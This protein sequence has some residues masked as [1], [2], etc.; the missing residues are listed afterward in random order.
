[1]SR[2]APMELRCPKCGCEYSHVRDVYTRLGAD[3]NEAEVYRGT[4][5]KEVQSAER[6]SAVSIMIKGECGHEWAVIIQQHKG[7]NTIAVEFE[8]N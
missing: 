6:R 1:M 3:P 4:V 2:E 8:A 5:V 7:I